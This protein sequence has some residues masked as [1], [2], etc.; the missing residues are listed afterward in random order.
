M[1]PVESDTNQAQAH[2]ATYTKLT[3]LNELD[4]QP[5][6][7]TNPRGHMVHRAISAPYDRSGTDLVNN[8]FI[9]SDCHYSLVR[10]W[11]RRW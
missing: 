5:V 4:G 10:L 3:D 8:I 11:R 9:E 2:Y 6:D 1:Y 7:L